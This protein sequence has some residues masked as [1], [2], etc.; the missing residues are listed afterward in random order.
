MVPHSL[1]GAYSDS[2]SQVFWESGERVFRRDWRLGR[3]AARHT[4]VFCRGAPAAFKRRSLTHEH[5]L[6]P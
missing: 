6:G 5:Q 4:D 2:G 3:Q 1:S